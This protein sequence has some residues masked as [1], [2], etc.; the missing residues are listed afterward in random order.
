MA[1]ISFQPFLKAD[2]KQMGSVCHVVLKMVLITICIMSGST[3]KQHNFNPNSFELLG[4][5]TGIY[6]CVITGV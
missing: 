1:D 2:D 4:F 5:L 6:S 3:F